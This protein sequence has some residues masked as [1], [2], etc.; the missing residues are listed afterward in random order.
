MMSSADIVK[1]YY[2]QNPQIEWN[3]LEGGKP[4]FEITMR[5][6]KENLK[7]N[8]KI[9]DV[10][11]GP[12]RYAFSLTELGHKVTLFDLSEGNI[13]FAKN[14][15]QE[16]GINLDNYICGNATQLSNYISDKYD[17][18]LCLGP[19]YH[20]NEEKDRI[21]VIN[22]C[23]EALKTNGIIA[24]GFISAYAKYTAVL[25]FL[26]QH[27]NDESKAD[28]MRNKYFEVVPHLLEYA[29][30]QS[31]VFERTDDGFTESNFTSPHQLTNYLESFGIETIVLTSPECL[32]THYDELRYLPKDIYDSLLNVTYYYAK[33]PALHGSSEHL[34]YLG[35]KK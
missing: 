29:Q 31:P 30:N 12:G 9:L 19:L 34:L 1:E 14:K 18:V 13:E 24:F 16:L 15:S 21:A 35:R 23:L 26:M 11:G 28:F 22:N 7:P 6:L 32:L 25:K 5:H 17:A 2:N 20:L 33:N 27:M 3:R 4:E 10:G 8:S